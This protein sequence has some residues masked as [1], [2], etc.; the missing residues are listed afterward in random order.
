MQ[1]RAVLV[2][3]FIIIT[4]VPVSLLSAI[5]FISLSK[6]QESISNIYQGTVTIIVNLSGGSEELLKMRLN[7]GRHIIAGDEQKQELAE[8]IRQNEVKFLQT[9]VNYKEIDDFPMQVPIL[10]SR[11]M[12]NLVSYED[13]LL[14]QVNEDWSAYQ[15]ERNIVLAL[16]NEGRQEEA[17]LYANSVAAEKFEKLITTYGEIVEL[18]NNLA[19]IMYEES[20]SVSTQAFTYSII[21]SVSSVIFASVAAL[22]LSGRL[23][24]SVDKIQQ[25]A[26]KKMERFI[27]ESRVMQKIT[28]KPGKESDTR[29][30]APEEVVEEAELK[31][32]GPIILLHSTGYKEA[33][34]GGDDEPRTV[35]NSFLDY[36]FAKA[37]EAPGTKSNLVVITKKSSNLYSKARSSGAAVYLLSSS[38]QEPISTSEDG[39]LVVSINQTSLI[40][41]AVKR[42]LQENP[43]SVIMLDNA[44]ELIHKLGFEKVF[45]LL[46]S[47][48]DAVSSYPR[49]KFLIL[50]NQG[51]HPQNEVEAIATISNTFA[52]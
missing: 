17:T 25:E 29:E 2:L 8:N 20:Q 46:Q 48:S 27:A 7:I 33:K 9:L 22:Y 21:S 52:R 38:S 36:Y 44:T 34:S 11:G 24:P 35:A 45:S 3:S 37:S 42:T 28:A 5:S 47:I 4:L 30:T 12:G 13:S 6:M 19:R 40:L 41:E 39:F 51:A 15:R 10:N 31:E 14:S 49:S 23:A 16:S 50:I 32:K 1:T 26:R 18:N 43:E